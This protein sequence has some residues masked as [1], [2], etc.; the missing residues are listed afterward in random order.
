MLI[1]DHLTV[2]LWLVVWNIFS[3][4]HMLGTI[5]PTDELIF[6]RWVG[7]ISGRE[8]RP[9]APPGHTWYQLKVCLEAPERAMRMPGVENQDRYQ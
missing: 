2:L 1:E 5:I 4:L 8:L 6:F 9:D 3:F 7:R